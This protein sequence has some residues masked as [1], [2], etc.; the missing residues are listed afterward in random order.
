MSGVVPALDEFRA[1][2]ARTLAIAEQLTRVQVEFTPDS[3]KWSVGEVLDH[4]ILA[5][6]VNRDQIAR[7]IEMKRQDRVAE[8]SLTFSEL[9]ISIAGVPHCI[10]SLLEGPITFMNMFVPNGL[11]NYLTRHRLIPFRNPDVATPQ[12]GR[13]LTELASDLRSSLQQTETLLRNNADLNFN[14]M[15]LRHPLL[16]SYNVPGLLRFMAAHEQRHQ[17]QINNILA[18]PRFPKSHSE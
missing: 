4:M 12:R 1:T 3:N 14:E 16:G 11:R 6:R 18:S 8:L 10:L 15:I 17:S 2:R 7:Q 13:S 9:N 5:E